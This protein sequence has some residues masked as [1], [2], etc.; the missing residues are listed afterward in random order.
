MKK[1]LIISNDQILK[2]KIYSNFNDTINIIQAISANSKIYLLS[3]ITN[4]KQNFFF[5]ATNPIKN[6]Y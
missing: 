1:V 3:R 2:K 4:L 5:K 6:R